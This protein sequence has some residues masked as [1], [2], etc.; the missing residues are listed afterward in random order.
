MQTPNQDVTAISNY[1]GT[2]SPQLIAQLLN[3]LD[4]AKDLKV[5]FNL[6][7]PLN[8]T[9]LIVNGGIRPLDTAVN[10]ASKPGRVWSK[11]V[12]HPRVGMKIFS[13]VPEELR[14]TWMSEMLDPN[15]IDVP[16]AQ[17]VWDQEFIKLQ[18]EI[19]DTVALMQYHG[20][21]VDFD[22]T[23]V[24]SPGN[25][26]VYGANRD[27]YQVITLTTAGQTPDTNSAKFTKI[28]ALSICDGP[29]TVLNQAITANEIPAG[30][31]IATG[32][33]DATNA[34]AKLRSVYLGAPVALRNKK[35]KMFVSYSVFENYKTNYDNTYG[36]PHGNILYEE[37]KKSISLYQSSG[38]CEIVPCTWLQGSS[39][40]IMTLPD[41]WIMGTNLLDDVNGLG[42]MIPTLHGFIAICKFILCFQFADAEVVYVND[43][44]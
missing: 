12:L 11:R 23:V 2:Y 17:W 6:K 16:F 10:T 28:T 4:I 29:L 34:V 40:V 27:I 41:N 8:L 24:Y 37:D 1:A 15:A 38:N 33:I 44:N 21:A 14:D 39:R 7:A 26:F 13:V 3:G 36:K 19:N 43:Q 32:A 25:T 35:T 42:K 31:I 9:K 22:A 30:Q 5:I 20:D 18:T